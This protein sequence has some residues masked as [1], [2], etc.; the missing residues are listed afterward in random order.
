MPSQLLAA[1]LVLLSLG[2]AAL[3][4]PSTNQLGDISILA[5]DDLISMLLHCS[6][7]LSIN[8]DPAMYSHG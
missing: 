3:A 5:A 4:T 6:C 7:R 8:T 1:C 2:K